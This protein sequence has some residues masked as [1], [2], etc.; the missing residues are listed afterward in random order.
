M[1]EKELLRRNVPDFLADVDTEEAWER[2]K[3]EIKDT[4]L[5]EEYGFLPKKLQPTVRVER[6][7]I[8][9]A[10][11]ADWDSVFF[12]FENGGKE[13]T[14]RCELVLPKEK[15]DVPVFLLI[16]FESKVPS[17]YNPTEEIIDGGFGVMAFCYKDVTTDDGDFTNGLC[18]LFCDENGKCSFGKISLWAYM[19]SVCAD[20]LENLENVGKIAI[21]GH[22]RLGKTALL[23][24]AM[25]ERF[26]LTCVN[27]SGC[28]GAALSRGKIEENESIRNITDVFPF[29][30]C[31]NYMKYRDNE[32]KLPFDQHLLI[33]QIAPRSVVVGGA[34]LDV[35]ADN[36]GQFL[37]CYLASDV[38]KL[39]GKQGIICENKLPCVNDEYLDAEVSFYLR[40]GAHFLSRYDWNMYMKKFSRLLN[41][42][43]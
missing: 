39:Y 21:I 37:S 36:E 34:L 18:G 23:A 32:D 38:W 29:W 10:A 15:K 5:R 40:S 17:K 28:S 42:A 2:K 43:D 30:F 25:D 26:F 13:H 31:E 33:A 19:A 11:K 12:T 3:A 14:V 6:Q 7:G 27:E 9:F 22:S 20:Y 35:W 4:F 16:D 8:N 41:E 1:I 24:S